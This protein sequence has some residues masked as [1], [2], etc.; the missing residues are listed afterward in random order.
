MV[1]AKLLASTASEAKCCQPCVDNRGQS[2]TRG[3]YPGRTPRARS[4]PLWRVKPHSLEVLPAMTGCFDVFAASSPNEGHHNCIC[5]LRMTLP[6]H[7]ERVG[8]TGPASCLGS[9]SRVAESQSSVPAGETGKIPCPMPSDVGQLQKHLANGRVMLPREFLRN[10]SEEIV[11]PGSCAEL[12]YQ[13]QALKVWH[14]FDALQ[15]EAVFLE[16]ASQRYELI[17]Q[18]APDQPGSLTPWWYRHT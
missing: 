1:S 9:S 18:H 10:H 16:L 2:S 14:G 15:E 6:N 17:M 5:N 8:P 12:K 4:S 11:C 3:S 13:P 7:W